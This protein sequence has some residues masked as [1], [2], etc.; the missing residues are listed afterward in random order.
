MDLGGQL[1]CCWVR[2]GG[3]ES[4]LSR[5]EGQLVLLVPHKAVVRSYTSLLCSAGCTPAEG[6]G[7]PEQD[8]KT[9]CFHTIKLFLQLEL[10]HSSSF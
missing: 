6:Q 7:S 3:A 1:P 4:R 5:C 8:E 2:A 10:R 9:G